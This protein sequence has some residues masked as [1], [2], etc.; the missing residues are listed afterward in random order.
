MDVLLTCHTSICLPSVINVRSSS[1]IFSPKKD[2]KQKLHTLDIN[3]SII[4]YESKD[5]YVW[6][7]WH[8]TFRGDDKRYWHKTY[9]SSIVIEYSC[10]SKEHYNYIDNLILPLF[11]RHFLWK[12]LILSTMLTMQHSQVIKTPKSEDVTCWGKQKN[13]MLLGIHK[14][15][16]YSS[17]QNTKQLRWCLMFVQEVSLSHFARFPTWRN[18][19]HLSTAICHLRGLT[20]KLA[21]TTE[22]KEKQK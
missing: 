15:W 11:I 3:P 16:F 14:H 10:F 13:K 18:S 4:Q 21:I 19:S 20:G 5:K 17:K 1:H 9:V 7:F 12:L 6:L 2:W 8:T 22:E